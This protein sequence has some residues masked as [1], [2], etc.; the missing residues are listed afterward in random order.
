M[1]AEFLS[2]PKLGETQDTQSACYHRLT[3]GGTAE[4]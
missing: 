3:N 2:S 4:L 1:Y